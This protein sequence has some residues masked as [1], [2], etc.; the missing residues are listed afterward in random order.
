MWPSIRLT[1]S[2]AHGPF[3]IEA[4]EVRA[5][6]RD[7]PYA[8]EIKAA[9]DSFGQS[10][11]RLFIKELGREEIRFSW[12]KDG[13][14]VVRPLDLPEDELLPLMKAAMAEGVFSSG[15]LEDL[16]AALVDHLRSGSSSDMAME[17]DAPHSSVTADAPH[18]A[19]DRRS[20]P[21][22]TVDEIMSVGRAV[23]ALPLLDDRTPDAIM[24]DLDP[25]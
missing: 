9:A 23:A 14:M 2:T 19:A 25:L 4:D 7:T 11:E 10:I 20:R 3:P 8:T 16:R 21:R 18:A 15:F 13:R 12:W 17:G 1:Q 5:D 22:M 6:V 24:D